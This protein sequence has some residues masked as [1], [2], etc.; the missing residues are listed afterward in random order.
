MDKKKN[1]RKGEKKEELKKEGPITSLN[2][3]RKW[4]DETDRKIKMRQK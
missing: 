3:N 1:K 4:C 2:L